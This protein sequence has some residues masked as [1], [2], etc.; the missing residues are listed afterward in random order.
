MCS[1]QSHP[2]SREPCPSV[3]H[4]KTVQRFP[5][6]LLK[7][8]SICGLGHDLVG[9]HSIRK[10]ARYQVAACSSTLRRDLEKV[11][12]ARGHNCTPLFA[13]SPAWEQEFLFPSMTFHTA[14]AFDIICVDRTLMT[15]LTKFHKT[16][17]HKVATSLLLDKLRKQDFAG[18]LSSRASRVLGPISRH[19]IADILPHMTR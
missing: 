12:E 2:Q 15:H 18:S 8:G 13:L 17:K 19:R 6:S 4:S 5:S 10:A 7:V 16:K 3:Y 9:I 11:N 14:N 1:R